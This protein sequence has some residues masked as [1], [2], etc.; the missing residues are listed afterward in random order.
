MPSWGGWEASGIFSAQS[1]LAFTPNMSFDQTN[2][3]SPSPRPNMIAN[4]NNFSFDMS[5]QAAM[6]CSQPGRQTLDC[7]YNQAA[8][9]LP[10]LAPGQTFARQFGNTANGV[11][12]GPDLF[13]F[14]F[15]AMKNFKFNERWTLQFR[16]EMF[17][18]FN[19]PN[20]GL[21]GNAV[22]VPGG[23]SISNTIPDN[24]REIQFAM[25]LLF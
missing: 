23:A 21:P 2:A 15:S 6:G 1:G 24:Q 9:V 13:S 18:I 8:F 25:K 22:D 10:P 4:P 14:D 11:L 3:G 12:R 16:A 19:H 5:T 17:N 20:F 7:Y